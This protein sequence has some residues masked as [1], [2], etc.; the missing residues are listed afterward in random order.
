MLSALFYGVNKV[1]KAKGAHALRLPARASIYYFLAAALT[2]G[3]GI[4]TTP[5]FTRILTPD[6][7]GEYTLYM[8]WLGFLSLTVTS[9][10][11]GSQGYAGLRRNADKKDMYISSLL[12][13]IFSF[14][15]IICILLF[16]FYTVLGLKLDLL[17]IL[18]VQ[19]FCDCILSVSYMKARYSY[20]FR[21][22]FI[23]SVAQA[24]LSPCLALILI[25]GANA[26]YHGRIYGL[27]IAS[28][29]VAL[30]TLS[31]LLQA[32]SRLFD[33]KLWSSMISRYLP[34]LPN[35]ISNALSLQTDRF[36][37]SAVMGTAALAK[38]S[39]A[40]SVGAALSMVVGALCSAL[41]PWIIRKLASNNPGAVAEASHRLFFLIGMAS[42]LIVAIAPE[43]ME[44]LAPEKYSDSLPAVL[45]LALA[46][47]PSLAITLSNT[48][49]IYEGR[50]G[51]VSL[52]ATA[53][54]LLGVGLGFIMIPS[55]KYFGAGIAHLTAQAVGA[56]I[57]IIF[58]RRSKVKEIL[59]IF[60]LIVCSA[61][62][63]LLAVAAHIMRDL[64][65]GRLTV[66][67]I[68]LAVIA[69][70][71]LRSRNLVREK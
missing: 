39:V 54:A 65:L 59:N 14:C 33:R 7:Y 57:I 58:L 70:Q 19:L 56:L 42:V 9:L 6:G 20:S 53:V 52:T 15:T 46:T 25:K 41:H 13:L 22:V 29:A 23:T 49:L 71:L 40:H 63:V 51:R 27:L 31:L 38:Y 35:V 61:L 10:A 43:A 28:V 47:L 5:I 26:A 16:A 60:S 37:I 18:S 11:S 36:I 69:F 34:L 4:L 17:I 21:R 67:L 48:A 68:A 3:I 32:H 24:I 44:L 2:K 1:E 55:L 30:P 64:P 8:S 66:S 12:G 62:S 50:E 45:P